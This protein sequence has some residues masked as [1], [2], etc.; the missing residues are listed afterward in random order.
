MKWGGESDYVKK[1]APGVTILEWDSNGIFA[2]PAG[3]DFTLKHYLDAG[4]PRWKVE[5]SGGG[6]EE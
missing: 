3:N 6:D 5:S 1:G 2:N 4:D